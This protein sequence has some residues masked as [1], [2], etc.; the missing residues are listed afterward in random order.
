MILANKLM[1]QD[2]VV[3]NQSLYQI[4]SNLGL[5][6]NLKLCLDAGDSASY[7]PSVQTAKW[8]DTSGNGYDFYRGTSTAGDAAEPTFNGAAGG[9][10]SNE[11]W[12]FDGS[13]YFK[14]DTTNE[15]W[16]NT[17]HNNGAVCS[18]V[19]VWAPGSMAVTQNLFGTAY[20]ASFVS[21]INF[22]VTSAN[23]VVYFIRNSLAG[24]TTTTV[25]TSSGHT[26]GAW[27][28]ECVSIDENG[29]AGGSSYTINGTSGTYDGNNASANGNTPGGF[30]IG[31]GGNAGDSW[32]SSGSKLACFAM[33][34]VELT[35]TQLSDIY[36]AI[37]GR[38]GL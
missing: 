10:S 35:P 21:G 7:N 6:T 33:W 4:I 14:Y 22:A 20:A 30:H 1:A 19:C 18:M 13:D 23:A 27:A 25:K 11:Y 17:L 3:G 5:T 8:L 31:T 26:A 28:I 37:K 16:M 29:G 32:L 9:L 15:T 34:D 38:F 24:G 36:N 2:A 12:S